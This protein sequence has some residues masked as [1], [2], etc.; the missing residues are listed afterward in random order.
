MRRAVPVRRRAPGAA[1]G[2]LPLAP[3]VLAAAVAA[4]GCARPSSP[5]GAPEESRPPAV[6][7]LTP[8]MD[9]VV[10]GLSGAAK[11]RFDEPIRTRSGLGRRLVA[12]PAYQY[13][14]SAG[15]SEISV[16]PEGGWRPDAVYVLEF[17]PGITDLLDNSRTEPVR[18]VFSTGPPIRPTR[19]ELRLFDR[20]TG[21]ERDR[22]RAL[23][24]PA[25]SEAERES[26]RAEADTAGVAA[27]TAG[28]VPYTAVADSAGRYV[29]RHLPPGTYWA[30]GFV[31]RNR[32][33]RLDRRLE[34]Y[35]SGRVDLSSDTARASAT[36][37]LLEPDS[38]PPRL[39]TVEARDSVT[40]RLTFD[41]HLRPGHRPREPSVRPEGGTNDLSVREVRVP[42]AADTAGQ[43]APP[44]DSVGSAS[45]DSPTADSA[46]ADV[47]EG[48]GAA[49]PDTAVGPDTLSPDSAADDSAASDT[50][51]VQ[52]PP[53]PTR[54]VEIRL[55]RPPSPDTFRVRLRGVRNMHGLEADVDTT[56]GFVPPP[57]TAGPPPDDSTGRDTT[58]RADSTVPDTALS[59]PDTLLPDSAARDTAAGR[60]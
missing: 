23:F 48:E 42:T 45:A 53:R 26:A 18:L 7:S 25:G 34:P 15:H 17:P 46:S 21:Q 8:A 10:P 36:L 35:D 33:L 44:A 14:V 39:A 32:N 56:F 41:D 22:G 1:A 20:V 38:T 43:R 31:D 60:P 30:F 16:R 50:A 29:L 13:S 51:E 40:I 24:L 5:P 12:S 58:F 54:I 3:L 37:F 47:P 28:P 57:D 4:W 55:A 19:V 59:S 9:T 27:D 2:G 52:K 11:I 6:R 49:T